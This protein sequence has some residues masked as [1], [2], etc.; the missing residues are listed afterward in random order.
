MSCESR[1]E[2]ELLQLLASGCYCGMEV[3]LMAEKHAVVRAYSSTY[4]PARW[5]VW[6]QLA[7]I[8]FSSISNSDIEVFAS[9]VHK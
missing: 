3:G 2:D 7:M 4:S 5:A 9:Y 1:F 8:D 6:S